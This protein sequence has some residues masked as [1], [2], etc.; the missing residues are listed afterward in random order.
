MVNKKLATRTTGPLILLL[1]LILIPS[2]RAGE[3]IIWETSSRTE[4]L[5][6]EARGVS[7]TDSGVLM[8]APRFTQIFNTDQAYIWS[9]AADGAG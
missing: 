8:L 7:I 3:P 1:L 5:K 6:G 9:S 4:L 2:V